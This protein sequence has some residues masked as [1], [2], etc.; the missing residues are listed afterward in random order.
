MLFLTFP[1]IFIPICLFSTTLWVS[2]KESNFH[3]V[4]ENWLIVV[5]DIEGSTKAIENGRSKIL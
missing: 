2:A 5:S 1:R 3:D 4:P